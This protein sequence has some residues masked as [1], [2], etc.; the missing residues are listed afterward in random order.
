VECVSTRHTRVPTI[1]DSEG[2]LA[3]PVVLVSTSRCI[4]GSYILLQMKHLIDMDDELLGRVKEILGT[5]TLKATVNAAL[6]LVEQ[7]APDQAKN[8]AAQIDAWAKLCEEIPL[9]DRQEAW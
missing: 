7:Q 2:Y 3:T 1:D 4:Y 5:Q 6:R 8:R 9:A